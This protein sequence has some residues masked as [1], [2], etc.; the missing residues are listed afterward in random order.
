[1]SSFSPGA[2]QIEA[3]ERLQSLVEDALAKLEA[4]VLPD[5]IEREKIDFKEEARTTRARWHSQRG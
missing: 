3:R 4:G 1:M 2:D 5:S